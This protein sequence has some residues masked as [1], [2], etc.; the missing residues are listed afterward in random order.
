M[1]STNCSQPLWAL[2]DCN[3]F[4][5]SCEKLFRPDLATRPVVVLSNNDGCIVARSAEA[6]ALGI[7]MGEPEFKARPL[8]QRHKVEVFSSNYALYG[9]ISARVMA[10]L[11]QLCPHV[12]QYSIDEAFVRLEGPMAA[13]A[14]DIAEQLRQTVRQWTGMTVSVGVAPTRTLAKVANHLAK[15]SSGV[16]VWNSA[17]PDAA[18]VLRAFPVRE[19]WG[20]GWRQSKKL[21]EIGVT[22][23]WGLREANDV[24]LRKFLTISG[25][26]TA[27]ELRGVPCINEEEGPVPRRT[28]VSSRSFGEK[29]YDLAS[30]EQAVG[31]FTVRAAERLRR[32]ELVAGGI[33]VHIR[34]SRHGSRPAFDATAQQPFFPPTADTVTMLQ[35]ARKTLDAIYKK[36]PAY[37]KAGIMLYDLCPVDC[38]QGN[39][40]AQATPGKDARN[41]ALMSALD[42]ING[43]FGRGSV[44]FGAEG[45][46]EAKWHLRCKNCSPSV[47]TNWK[48]LA[49]AFCR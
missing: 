18:A 21:L 43:K 16:C 19:V 1:S 14:S 37:A 34:T 33:A 31:T 2:V 5:A 45:P 39:L 13:N 7:P 47:T 25:W 28:L 27:M 4:Y 42:T 29:V 11:E 22:S 41:D 23:A 40:L 32:Q 48:E 6:K 15:K 9:D 38:Q 49:T 46:K 20:I 36:G 30:L 12:E 35:A 10:T 8:L 3:N 44:R 24:W 17:L 26:K